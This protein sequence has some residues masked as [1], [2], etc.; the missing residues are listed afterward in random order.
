MEIKSL[1]LL[2]FKIVISKVNINQFHNPN[3]AMCSLIADRRFYCS[4]YCLFNSYNLCLK[5]EYRLLAECCFK[6]IWFESA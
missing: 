5:F 1:F 4:P 2:T 3:R 6:E